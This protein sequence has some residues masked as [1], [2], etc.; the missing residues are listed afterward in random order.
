MSYPVYALV[1][2]SARNSNTSS[3]LFAV[4]IKDSMPVKDLVQHQKHNDISMV[5][6]F[7]TTAS[8]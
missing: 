1:V 7:I 4:N 3:Y 8:L 5:L 6:A 2:S